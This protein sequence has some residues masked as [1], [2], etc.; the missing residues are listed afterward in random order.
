MADVFKRLQRIKREKYRPSGSI[1]GTLFIDLWCA[2]CRANIGQVCPI[3]NATHYNRHDDEYPK[4][5][6]YDDDGQP[7]CTAFEQK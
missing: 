6:T 1:E 7:C 2:E 4:E 5:W 3:L